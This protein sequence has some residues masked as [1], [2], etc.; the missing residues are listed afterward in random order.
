MGSCGRNNNGSVRQ[1]IR[2]KVPRL[3]WTPDLH[4]CFVQA[5][6]RLGGQD[7]ATPK[8]VMQLMDV[9]GLTISHVKSHLQ[10]YRSMRINDQSN[11]NGDLHEH[12][13]KE[14]QYSFDEHDGCIDEVND[15]GFLQA[16]SSSK[17]IEDTN[18]H[19]HHHQSLYGSLLPPKRP[20]LEM[21]CSTS[22]SLHFNER[23]CETT[24]VT[25]PYTTYNNNNAIG[26]GGFI[27]QHHHQQ[28][29]QSQTGPPNNTNALFF[30]SHLANEQQ[31]QL[32][33]LN[34]ASGFL[35]HHQQQESSFPK[36]ISQEEEL[37]Q[38]SVCRKRKLES[39]GPDYRF[40]SLPCLPIECKEE[41]E[42]KDCTLSLSLRPTTQRSN[43]S[44]ASDISDVFS[45]SRLNFHDCSG[46]S[47]TTSMKKQNINLDLSISLCGI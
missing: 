40:L 30:S 6:E 7:R 44:S 15:V 14:Q 38:L 9:R 37:Q 21:S 18:L 1:Y 31:H 11:S 4:H 33:N 19:I 25:S 16:S 46:S 34:N 43:T 39:L 36:I 5:I 24:A 35:P 29:Q 23:M 3:R 45:S 41:N 27:F 42:T 20:R 17:S 28:Q 26:S 47:S 12:E 13:Q 32:Y 2:S 22:Q 10:M 8:L